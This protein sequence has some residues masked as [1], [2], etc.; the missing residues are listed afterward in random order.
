MA[1][2]HVGTRRRRGPDG[3]SLAGEPAGDGQ[4]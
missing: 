2:I 1:E 4:G 3:V